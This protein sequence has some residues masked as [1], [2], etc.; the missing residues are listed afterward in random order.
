MLRE[1]QDNFCIWRKVMIKKIKIIFVLSFMSL[2]VFVGCKKEKTEMKFSFEESQNLFVEEMKVTNA[3]GFEPFYYNKKFFD[4]VEQEL[5]ELIKDSDYCSVTISVNINNG[6]LDVSALY[7]LKNEIHFIL[8]DCYKD[9]KN[10]TTIQNPEALKI[11]KS[12]PKKSMLIE[13][14]NMPVYDGTSEYVIKKIGDKTYHYAAYIH[15][16]DKDY[17]PLLELFGEGYAKLEDSQ[18][19]YRIKIDGKWGF[20]NYYGQ[21]KIYPEYSSVEDFQNGICKVSRGFG[22]FFINRRNQIV[23]DDKKYESKRVDEF[24]FENTD[25]VIP[26]DLSLIPDDMKLSCDVISKSYMGEGM[27]RVCYK[28]DEDKIGVI[29]HEGKIIIEPSFW[30]IGD[31]HNGMAAFKYGHNGVDGYIRKDGKIFDFRKYYF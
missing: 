31:F 3:F 26:L 28:N 24:I 18:P 9:I 11:L 2:A 8:W 27:Y 20:I 30:D 22:Y 21:I 1:N 6:I 5:N 17:E 14:A 12:K 16:D 4:K 23:D 29:T 13:N 10:H 15:C 25:P 7:N 19:L